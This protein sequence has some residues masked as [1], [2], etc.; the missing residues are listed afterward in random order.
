MLLAERTE[1]APE[2][3]CSSM[4]HLSVIVQSSQVVV[5]ATVE[6]EQTTLT[7]VL[8]A[9]LFTP[10]LDNNQEAMMPSAD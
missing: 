7:K 3:F 5:A 1:K 6:A 9:R 4:S 10:N 2:I 8:M